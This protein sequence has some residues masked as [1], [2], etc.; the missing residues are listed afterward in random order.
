MPLNGCP[1]NVLCVHKTPALQLYFHLWEQ[2]KVRWCMQN[3]VS[4][5][6]GAKVQSRTRE[7]LLVLGQ[8]CGEVHCPATGACF[9]FVVSVAF[10][11]DIQSVMTVS[12]HNIVFCSLCFLESGNLSV[13]R[14]ALSI[15][16]HSQH[17]FH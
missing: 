10:F 3:L 4:R 2:K 11:F 7:S 15:P 1:G 9:Q 6:G 12:T 14:Y 13:L 8:L 17:D 5:L 16:K